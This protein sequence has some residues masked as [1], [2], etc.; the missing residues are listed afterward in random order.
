VDKKRRRI[1]N[2]KKRCI[3]YTPSITQ[4]ASSTR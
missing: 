1:K 4:K 3:D 2:W